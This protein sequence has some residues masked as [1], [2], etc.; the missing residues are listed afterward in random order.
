MPAPDAAETPALDLLADYVMVGAVE[1]DGRFIL[2]VRGPDGLT[3]ALRLGDMLAGHR[4]ASIELT[5]A[6]LVRD[7]V[8]RRLATPRVA[9]S[10]P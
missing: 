3:H 8:E 2:L 7:G 10:G 1:A 9:P 5:E 4:V 6:R